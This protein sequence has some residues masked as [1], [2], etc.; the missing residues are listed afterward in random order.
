[1]LYLSG[2]HTNKVVVALFIIE[3]LYYLLWICIYVRFERLLM[4][5]VL[6]MGDSFITS[7]ILVIPDV[8]EVAK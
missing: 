4:I 6:I 2:H 7:M 8:A 1:V 5:F 3:E